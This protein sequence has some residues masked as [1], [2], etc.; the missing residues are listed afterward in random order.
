ML[1]GSGTTASSPLAA[2][3]SPLPAPAL[4]LCGA[5][6]AGSPP[7]SGPSPASV[8]PPPLLPVSLCH[9]LYPT[10]MPLGLL[11]ALC[12]SSPVYFS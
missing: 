3:S 4:P 9:W 1:Q 10:G 2:A 12:S 6:S 11:K 7:A 5:I 8:D